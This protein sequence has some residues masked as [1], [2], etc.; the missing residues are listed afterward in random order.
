MIDAWEQAVKAVSPL[1]ADGLRQDLPHYLAYERAQ[2]VYPD[3]IRAAQSLGAAIEEAT[4]AAAVRRIRAALLAAALPLRLG[5]LPDDEH[6]SKLLVDWV[7]SRA[8]GHVRY[9]KVR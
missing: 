4:L 1:H 8:A 2:S 3:I 5:V 6:I 9:R 7:R